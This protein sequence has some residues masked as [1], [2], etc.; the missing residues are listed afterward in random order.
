MNQSITRQRTRS[1]NEIIQTDTGL[2]EDTAWKFEFCPYPIE[3]LC[4]IRQALVETVPGLAEKFHPKL[5][6][7]GYRVGADKEKV[8]IYVL[9][10]KLIIDLCIN[11]SFIEELRRTGFKVKPRNNFQGQRGWLTGWEVPQSTLNIKPVVKWLCKAL[12]DL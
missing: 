1:G 12:K 9:K 5:R 2:L 6:Y 10:K 11:P 8:Y 7:F 4:S 3:L